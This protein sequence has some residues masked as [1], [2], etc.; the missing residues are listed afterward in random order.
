[1]TPTVKAPVKL[2]IPLALSFALFVL[3]MISSFVKPYGFFIDEV[4]FLS[5]A[6]RPALGYIDQPPL[7]ILLLSVVQGLFGDNIHAVRVLPALSMAATVFVTGL[8]T[9]RLGGGPFSLLLACL[10]VMVM[11]V[12][13]LFESFYSMNAFEPLIWTAVVYFVVKLVQ[14]HD[15]SNWLPIGIL[16]GIGLEMKHTFVLYGLALIIGMLISGKRRLLWNYWLLWGGLAAFLILLPNLIW[17]FVNDFPSLELYRNSFTYKNIE[18][19]SVQ[20]MIEQIVFANPATFPLWITGV[21]ALAF[22]RGKEFRLMLFGWLFLMAVM[23]AGHSS[24][25]DR[26]ASIYTFL[27]AFGAVTIERGLKPIWRRPVQ[28]SMAML[29]ITGGVL[30]TPVF[31]PLMSP[32]PLKEHIE[33][34]GLKMDIEE[35][36]KGEPIPQWLADRIGWHE[37]AVEVAGVYQALPSAERQNAVII[38]SNYG[39]AGALELYGPEL[40]LPAVYATHN[41]F[42]TWGPPSDSVKTYI[43]V[44][45]D[46]EDVRPMFD[47]V[48]EAT[49]VHCPDCTRPQREIPVYILRGPKFSVEKEWKGFRIYG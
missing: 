1:M 42:H 45:I 32:Q 12:Y 27:I 36:K 31:I 37:L 19:S 41:A 40:G 49:V 11:P 33:R 4:Y 26:I 23:I 46:I 3:L 28:I 22:H 10:A 5:C 48:E 29:M 20:I 24:R 21:I 39:H 2:S 34:L 44:F 9:R 7:S 17:Q 43:G 47:S 14:D 16:S 38:S 25:P 18:K 15:P 30:L 13:L 35:G 8:I 6:R